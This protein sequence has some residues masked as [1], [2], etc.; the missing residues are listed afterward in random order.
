M[1][2]SFS[3]FV[4]WKGKYTHSVLLINVRLEQKLVQLLNWISLLKKMKYLSYLKRWLTNK[5]GFE[6]DVFLNIHKA[7]L[8]MS[9]TTTDCILLPMIKFRLSS[10]NENFGKL[11]SGTVSLIASR[12]IKAFLISD[13]DG[14][15][16]LILYDEMCQHQEDQHTSVN[17]YFPNA[18]CL[19]QNHACIKAPFRV[20]GRHCI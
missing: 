12:H 4:W 9:R 18:Q 13:T 19:L 3:D 5:C 11:V 15:D 6:G 1:S 16:F 17:Q 14:C 8:V 7:S 2:A 10:K 20:P